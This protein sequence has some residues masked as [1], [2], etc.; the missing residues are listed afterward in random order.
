MNRLISF[1]PDT[2]DCLPL[3]AK[4]PKGIEHEFREAETCLGSGCL[5]AGAGLFRSV[6]DKVFR[7]NGY[8]KNRESLASQIDAACE[9][10]VITQS[11]KNKAHEEIRVLGNDVLHDDWHEIP[12][13]DVLAARRYSQRVL[14]DFYDDRSEVERIL[15]EAGRITPDQKT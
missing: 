13:A 8:K 6:L 11:R 9:D 12:E 10:G 15:T 1:T 3:P 7:A 2:I 14:E 5:R 4:V